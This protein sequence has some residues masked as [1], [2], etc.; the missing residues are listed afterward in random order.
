MSD[1]DRVSIAKQKFLV[2]VV[3]TDL[4]V[5]TDEEKKRLEEITNHLSLCGTTSGWVLPSESDW[6]RYVKT[7]P[8]IEE[9]TPNQFKCDDNPDTHKHY[10]LFA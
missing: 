6:E 5:E 3:C 8:E 4:P 2:I 9:G 1:L 7:N 10:V